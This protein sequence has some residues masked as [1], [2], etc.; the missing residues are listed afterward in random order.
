MAYGQQGPRATVGQCLLLLPLVVAQP[1]ERLVLPAAHRV[2]RVE[3]LD[4]D[5]LQS[6]GSLG[7]G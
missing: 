7:R 4:V 3:L 5:T 1:Q 6:V 2:G